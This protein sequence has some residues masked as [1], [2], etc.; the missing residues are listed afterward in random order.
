MSA[1]ELQQKAAVYIM[2]GKVYKSV[3]AALAAAKKNAQ[4]DDVIFV[5]GSCFTVAEVM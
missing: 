3:G 1:D 5:G 2:Y 4:P